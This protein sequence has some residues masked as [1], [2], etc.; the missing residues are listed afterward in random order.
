[1]DLENPYLIPEAAVYIGMNIL[2]TSREGY[3]IYQVMQY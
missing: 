1:M 2:I 3:L